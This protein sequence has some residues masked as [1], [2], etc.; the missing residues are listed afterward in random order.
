MSTPSTDELR[1]QVAELQRENAALH[2]A[3]AGDLPSAI[4]WL[5]R[6]VLRQR[7]TL[8]RLQRKGPGH[9]QAERLAAAAA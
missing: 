3:L 1:Q 6:K 7:A 2:A 8:D 9:T 5:Y 4:A